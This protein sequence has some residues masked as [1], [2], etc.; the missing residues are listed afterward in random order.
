[1]RRPWDSGSSTAASDNSAMSSNG[2]AVS[3]G[4]RRAALATSVARLPGRRFPIKG[5]TQLTELIDRHIV[6]EESEVIHETPFGVRMS[7]DLRDYV[8]RNIFYDAWEG[9]ELNFVHT[10]LR[11]GDLMVDVGSN[12]GLFSLVAAKAVGDGGKVYAFEPVP[13][14]WKRCEE[15]IRLNDLHNITLSRTALSDRA[16]E[17][18]L[19]IDANM[20]SGSGSETSGFFTMSRVSTA[21]REVTA[22]AESFDSFAERELGERRIRVV[23]IDVEGAEPLVM[24]GMARTLSERRIDMFVVEVSVYALSVAGFKVHEI[25]APLEAAGFALYR[26]G[27]GGLLWRW[28]YEGEPRIPER[29]DMRVP[30]ITGV[31]RG[32]QDLSRLFNLV[33]VRSDHPAVAGR[34]R[35][36]PTRRLRLN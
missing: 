22:H 30:F 11:P 17:V 27:V 15:N 26:L 35:L 20:A 31:F 33:A 3:T 18:T 8:Q 32:I 24:R 16:G 1:M 36:L 13:G 19:A 25:V 6:R 9:D 29:S 12:V 2:P 4:N 10:V 7:L 28:S 14:N 23:K 5:W 21:V 34:P